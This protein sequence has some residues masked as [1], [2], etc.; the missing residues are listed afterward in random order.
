MNQYVKIYVPRPPTE[1]TQRDEVS[2]VE[3]EPEIEIKN[4]EI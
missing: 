4:E 3:K 2:E 1:I